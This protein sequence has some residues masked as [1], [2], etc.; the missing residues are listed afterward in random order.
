MRNPFVESRSKR[1]GE[2][3]LQEAFR[4]EVI[5]EDAADGFRTRRLW[6]RLRLAPGLDAGQQVIGHA[7]TLLRRYTGRGPATSFLRIRN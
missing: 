6:I 4:A 7:D 3:L 2:I 1:C 5:C